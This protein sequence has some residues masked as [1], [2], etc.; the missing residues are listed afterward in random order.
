MFW[1]RLGGNFNPKTCNSVP[2]K[3]ISVQLSRNNLIL[4]ENLAILA[5]ESSNPRAFSQLL[6]FCSWIRFTPCFFLQAGCRYH[7]TVL[8]N[9]NFTEL[10]SISKKIWFFIYESYGH[11][12]DSKRLRISALHIHVDSLWDIYWSVHKCT[13]RS[14]IILLI[15]NVHILHMAC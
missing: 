2:I 10:E 6:C 11:W 3:I 8:G 12:S 1:G 5:I 9:K 13:C 7:K 14:C 15:Q 4:T